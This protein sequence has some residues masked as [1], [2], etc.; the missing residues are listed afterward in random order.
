VL[1]VTG[2]LAG[3]VISLST[4]NFLMV[5]VNPQTRKDPEIDQVK[6]KETTTDFVPSV[7]KDS[8]FLMFIVYFQR[9]DV[10]S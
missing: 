9:V 10:C 5:D 6:D 2:V 8:N 7:L 4:I 1:F 3:G